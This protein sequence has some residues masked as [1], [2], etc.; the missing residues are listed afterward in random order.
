MD[1]SDL[2]ENRGELV[3]IRLLSELH[4]AR[5]EIANT[6]DIPAPIQV[7]IYIFEM[8]LLVHNGWGLALRLR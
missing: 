8:N 5:V 4:F 2:R 1:A 3:M 7:K 6:R